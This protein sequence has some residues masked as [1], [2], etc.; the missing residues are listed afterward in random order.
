MSDKE[1]SIFLCSPKLHGKAQEGRS[2]AGLE[3][4][5]F[6]FPFGEGLI[7]SAVLGGWKSH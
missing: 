3:P 2:G 1:L 5:A 4:D 6:F 7:L